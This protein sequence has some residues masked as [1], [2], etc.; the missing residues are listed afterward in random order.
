MQSVQIRIR[1]V[2]LVW[3]LGCV[4]AL[5]YNWRMASFVKN[6]QLLDEN[7]KIEDL[8]DLDR[9][10]NDFDKKIIGAKNGSMIGLV[11]E[12]GSGK[13]TLLHQVH[14]MRSEETL[15]IEFDAWKFPERKDLWEGF[16]LEFARHIDEEAFSEALS[17]I[18]GRQ[19]DDKR[20]L[21]DTIASIPVPG[22]SAVKGLNHFFST[23]PARRTFEVQMVLDE[24]IK[25][26]CKEKDVVIIV[27]DI[28]RSGDAGIFFLETLKHYLQ[29]SQVGAKIKAVVP[30]ANA[31]FNQNQ[32]SYLKCLDIIEHFAMRKIELTKFVSEIFTP[33]S[34]EIRGAK[35]QMTQFL[36]LMLA[37]PG[38]TL[39]KI[40]QILRKS[41]L[42]YSNQ[43]KDEL[44]PDFRMTIMFEMSKYVSIPNGDGRSYFQQF[45]QQGRVAKGSDF[46]ALMSAM[47]ANSGL[48]DRD[49]NP[50]RG[51]FNFKLITRDTSQGVKGH[52]S[53]PWVISRFIGE[54]DDSHFNCDFYLDY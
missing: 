51:S 9:L 5:V 26:H 39:R 47:V 35:Q 50:N 8:L 29:A 21:V 54:I 4:R 11:G 52:P 10:I 17:K 18:D 19:D 2:V 28:D 40:K 44:D 31:M 48:L 38:M 16:V 43:V 13:S 42:N 46:N 36:E 37:K 41:D 15:W 23:T 6:H 7:H 49:G 14:L 25:K 22:F 20:T 30:I 33:E 12:Y 34:L 53:I 27:E 32:D 3:V 24:L 1:V 45:I